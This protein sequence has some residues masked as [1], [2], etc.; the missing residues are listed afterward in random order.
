MRRM[1]NFVRKWV[2]G[3][4]EMMLQKQPTQNESIGRVGRREELLIS[5]TGD[6]REGMKGVNARGE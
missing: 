3:L 1:K 5:H 2:P 6:S 4:Q